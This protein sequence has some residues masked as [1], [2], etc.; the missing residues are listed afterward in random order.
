MSRSRLALNLFMAGLSLVFLIC[1][2]DTVFRGGPALPI[3]VARSASSPAPI[4]L[5]VTANTRSS[6]VY[7]LIPAR[8]L[9]HPDRAQP[10]RSDALVAVPPAASLMLYGL[11]WSEDSPLA[12]LE[13]PTTKKIFGYKTG[14]AMAGGYVERIELDRVVIRRT[15][16]PLEVMLRAPN[17]PRASPATLPPS[18][19]TADGSQG[20]RG[21]RSRTE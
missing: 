4:R 7:E 9:F 21:S 11:V 2:V 17:K 18:P 3:R 1:I 5:G 12:Y 19:S 8:N 15:D 6:A 14:D 20:P 10:K 16:G 13:D